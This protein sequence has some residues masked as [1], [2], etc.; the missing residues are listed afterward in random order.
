MGLSTTTE[1]QADEL[2]PAAPMLAEPARV[3]LRGGRVLAWLTQPVNQLLA[4]FSLLPL[5][6]VVGFV[7]ERGLYDTLTH[8]V[9]LSDLN[10]LAIHQLASFR[11]IDPAYL[12]IIPLHT[13]PRDSNREREGARFGFFEFEEGIIRSVFQQPAPSVSM[14]QVDVP[15]TDNPVIFFSAV[16]VDIPD[17]PSGPPPD[18]VIFRVALRVGDEEGRLLAEIDYDPDSD[19]ELKRV[20]LPLD[21]YRGQTIELYL[22]TDDRENPNAD[23]AMW[24]DPGVLVLPAEED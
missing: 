19:E 11:D 21:A 17:A 3:R 2:L 15:Q 16:H 5:V 7:N 8:D 1:G 24:V 23:N 10:G 13:L 20:F 6:F 4:L 14:F 18:G 9:F 12:D 22:Q